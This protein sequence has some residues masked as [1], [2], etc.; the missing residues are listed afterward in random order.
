MLRVTVELLPAGGEPAKV[1]HT[2]TITNDETGSMAVGN[3]ALELDGKETARLERYPRK[4][5]ALRLAQRA[6]IEFSS[7]KF[8]EAL[9]LSRLTDE[10][11]PRSPE[12][13][14]R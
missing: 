5:G 6:L 2:V 11:P 12:T 3:Y 8:R 4:L 13:A 9:K 10:R 7:R 1:L 14:P